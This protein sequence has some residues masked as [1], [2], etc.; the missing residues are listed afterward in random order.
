MSTIPRDRSVDA[1]FALL[2]EGHEFIW[3]RCRRHRTEI[4]ETRLMGK[5]AV[6]V[7][8][9]EAAELFC[10]ESRLER[11]GAT[12]TLGGPEHRRWRASLAS[13]ASLSRLTEV[14]AHDY[15]RAIRSW[16]QRD[17]IV[18]FD[19]VQRVLTRAASS[20]AGLP[21]EEVD[22][23]RRA[24]DLGWMVEG[25]AGF[26]PRSWRGELARARLERWMEG[27]IRAVRRG[28]HVPPPDSVLE[29]VTSLRG[30]GGE[31]L[32]ARVAARA[33]ID[34]LSPTMALPWFLAFAALALHE[35]PAGRHRIARELD[36]GG[37]YPDLFVAE[38]R[39]FYPLSPFLRA[40]VRTPF[41]WRGYRFRV[42]TLVLLDVYGMN[43]DAD[44]WDVPGELRPERFERWSGAAFHAIPQG[45][46]RRGGQGRPEEDIASHQVTL[47]LHF[48]TR[49]MTHELAA[50]QDLRF[51]L[52][53]MPARPR[54]G[55]V[56]RN[57]RATAALDDAP[58]LARCVTVARERAEAMDGESIHSA[59]QSER[60]P[61]RSE[62]V[63]GA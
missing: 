15:R 3:N 28:R 53:R 38:V 42:G 19:E 23:V 2:R 45:G 24:R 30:A 57:L 56:L 43:H 5:R 12:A 62:A 55:V 58:P 47:A 63:R 49:C 34:V 6:C 27:V 17:S 40:T 50:G 59:P 20:W 8:G 61:I 44:L 1:T 4:F 29:V 16:E 25:A 7:H 41:E 18:L 36:E 9:R 35:H 21:L 26:G 33:L 11:P 31:P 14:T 37:E 48:L 54:S 22:V 32:E 39:R 52:A 60:R 51:D 10:D 46:G 13:P